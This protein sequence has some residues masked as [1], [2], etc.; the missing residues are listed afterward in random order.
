M[1]DVSDAD[2]QAALDNGSYWASADFGEVAESDL[3]VI[4][5]PTRYHDV[6]LGSTTYPGAREELLLPLLERASGLRVGVD[7]DFPL[8]IALLARGAIVRYHD[9]VIGVA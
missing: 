7:F 1:S 2:L 8:L 9:L 3:V 4:C 6:I 5:V